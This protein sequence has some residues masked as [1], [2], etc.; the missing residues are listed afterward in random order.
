MKLLHAV[1]QRKKRDLLVI[2]ENKMLGVN[3]NQKGQT[4]RNYN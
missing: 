1:G 2:L 4:F 3:S